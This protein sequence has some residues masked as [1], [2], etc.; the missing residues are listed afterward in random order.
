MTACGSDV[1]PEMT[2][3]RD[4][5]LP[6]ETELSFTMDEGIRV[7]MAALITDLDET[8][9]NNETAYWAAISAVSEETF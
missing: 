4:Q 1:S 9:P 7:Y 3:T 8:N 5:G 2:N 6:T